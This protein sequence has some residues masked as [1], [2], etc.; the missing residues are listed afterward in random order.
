MHRS[1]GDCDNDHDQKLGRIMESQGVVVHKL[2]VLF[3]EGFSFIF[4]QLSARLSYWLPGIFVE[5]CKVVEFL[6]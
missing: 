4:P 6:P 2:D 3:S 1:E 5:S